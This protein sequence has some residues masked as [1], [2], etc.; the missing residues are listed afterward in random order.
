MV[1]PPP[2]PPPCWPPPPPPP[3]QP[4]TPSRLAPTKPA[5]L[6]FRKSLR[7]IR[8]TP[9]DLSVS[10]RILS[11]PTDALLSSFDPKT[12]LIPRITIRTQVYE[13]GSVSD[14]VCSLHLR[15]GSICLFPLAA[16]HYMYHGNFAF[17]FLPGSGRWRRRPSSPRTTWFSDRQR[18]PAFPSGWRRPGAVR[19]WNLGLPRRAVPT[20]NRRRRSRRGHA[21]VAPRRPQ[22]PVE[23]RQL[24][25]RG[26]RCGDRTSSGNGWYG[27]SPRLSPPAS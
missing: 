15:S 8:I 4:A 1:L 3:P 14:V 2:P 19:S 12:C 6:I 18:S 23:P 16:Q 17:R 9:G 22:A 11:A 7:L 26:W 10:V 5:P 24:P 13:L 21:H 27:T 20:T 25:R